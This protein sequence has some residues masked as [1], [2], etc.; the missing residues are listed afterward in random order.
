M[1][2]VYLLKMCGEWLRVRCKVM[3][4]RWE[5]GHLALEIPEGETPLA[6]SPPRSP[7]GVKR[8]PGCTLAG[9]ASLS[10]PVQRNR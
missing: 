1:L 8:N 2:S 9:A 10:I 3:W 4:Y 6:P 7:D 5:R